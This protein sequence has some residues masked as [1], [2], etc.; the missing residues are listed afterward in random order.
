MPANP[1]S[2]RPDNRA[3]ES[4]LLLLTCPNRP[5]IIARVAGHIFG[6]DF[7]IADMIYRWRIEELPV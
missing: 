5:G 6:F 7:N 4:H 1:T 3:S 2:V